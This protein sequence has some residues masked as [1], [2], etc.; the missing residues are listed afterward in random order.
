MLFNFFSRLLKLFKNSEFKRI[1]R[2]HF[3]NWSQ[4]PLSS[5]TSL[6]FEL[7]SHNIFIFDLN[8]HILILLSFMH[9]YYFPNLICVC[10]FPSIYLNE[11]RTLNIQKDWHHLQIKCWLLYRTS[12]FIWKTST[13]FFCEQFVLV[14][15]QKYKNFKKYAWTMIAF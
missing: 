13:L 10:F 2:Q 1:W 9:F 11:T 5:S 7:Y 14:G 3:Q 4:K 8:M 6:I 15:R 12:I